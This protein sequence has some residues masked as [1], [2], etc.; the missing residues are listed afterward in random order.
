MIMREAPEAYGG[1]QKRK[2]EKLQS[3]EKPPKSIS[4]PQASGEAVRSLTLTLSVLN[5]FLKEP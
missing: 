2:K 3:K 4:I 1:K 5:H